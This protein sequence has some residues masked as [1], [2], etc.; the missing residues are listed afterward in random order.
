MLFMVLFAFCSPLKAVS[1]LSPSEKRSFLSTVS[2]LLTSLSNLV[3]AEGSSSFT[4][5]KQ[6]L[7]REVR[8]Q[9]RLRLGFQNHLNIK[10]LGNYSGIHPS[11][12]TSEGGCREML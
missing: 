4:E 7:H 8:T 5:A 11:L 9:I 1:T 12:I 2:C 3:P 6:S 10:S